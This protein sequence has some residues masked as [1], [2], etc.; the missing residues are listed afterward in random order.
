MHTCLKT[1]SSDYNYKCFCAISLSWAGV[2]LGVVKGESQVYFSTLFTRTKERN[3]KNCE[4]K[5]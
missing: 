3:W 2:K 4:M 5:Q 1:K